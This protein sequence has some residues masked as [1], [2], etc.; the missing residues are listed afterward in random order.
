MLGCTWA[1]SSADGYELVVVM[2]VDQAFSTAVS[3]P[4]SL[5]ARVISGFSTVDGKVCPGKTLILMPWMGWSVS[6]ESLTQ[7]VFES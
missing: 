3:G 1:V 5:A 6:D 4:F 7:L 2:F